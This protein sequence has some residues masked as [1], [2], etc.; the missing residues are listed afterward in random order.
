MSQLLIK[1]MHPLLYSMKTQVSILSTH[2][3][4]YIGEHYTNQCT[5][6]QL[7]QLSLKP[8]IYLLIYQLHLF[9]CQIS[10]VTTCKHYAE[11]HLTMPVYY[12][13][14]TIVYLLF[15]GY[16]GVYARFVQ[17]SQGHFVTKPIFLYL[18]P[19]DTIIDRAELIARRSKVKCK[20]VREMGRG[21]QIYFRVSVCGL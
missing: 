4:L 5:C 12:M 7:H 11:P 15:R 20:C 2:I 18:V 17:V 8:F 19:D 9:G 14:L 16:S 10:D 1:S 6:T 13:Y 3:D 21:G